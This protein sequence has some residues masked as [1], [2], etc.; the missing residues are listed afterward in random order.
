MKNPHRLSKMNAKQLVREAKAE[1]N[2]DLPEE[3]GRETLLKC[4]LRLHNYKDRPE[5]PNKLLEIDLRSS[6]DSRTA[7]HI[8]RKL[9]EKHEPHP[10][11]NPIIGLEAIGK[12]L[13]WKHEY[14]RKHRKELQDA[15]VIH[16]DKVHYKGQYRWMYCAYPFDL[17]RFNK[18][19]RTKPE[20]VFRNRR[21]P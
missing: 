20:T 11:E 2:I 7:D 15:K 18:E 4:V 3:A 16:W 1:F 21:L 13:G 6:L 9:L 17:K 14:T 12:C 8:I 5:L 19:R 10:N